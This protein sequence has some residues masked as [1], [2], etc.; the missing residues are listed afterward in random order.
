LN[1]KKQVELENQNLTAQIF[2]LEQDVE[3]INRNYQQK[4]E[5]IEDTVKRT[6]ENEKAIAI[7]Q[8]EIH[9]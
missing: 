1:Q 7:E 8:A 6:L 9:L 2:T 4:L 3:R 5:L